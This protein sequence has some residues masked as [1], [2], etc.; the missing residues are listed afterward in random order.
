MSVATDINKSKKSAECIKNSEQEIKLGVLFV[1][2][3]NGG[4][5][6]YANKRL[7]IM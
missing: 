4:L 3:A 2:S 6:Y 5:K 1:K 7:Y